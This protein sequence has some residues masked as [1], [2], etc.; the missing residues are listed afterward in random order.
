MA[1]R[2]ISKSPFTRRI[3]GFTQ[4]TLT[5][6]NGKTDPVEHVNHFN[7]RM[8]VHLKNE[9]LMC[10]VFPSSLR[11]MAMRWFD[12]LQEGSINSFK[13]L[14]RAFGARFVTCSRV[15]RPLNSLLSMTMREGE[16]LKT[17][18][19]KYWEM[20]NKIDENFD[21]VAIRTLKVG[22]PIEYDLRK[23]LTRK[24]VRNR[25]VYYVSNLLHEAEVRYL[26]LEKAI[27]PVVHATQKL[28]YYFQAHI[29][30]VLT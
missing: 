29:V 30:V 19:D 18:L 24:P 14:T 5:M 1:L 21:D 16:T 27:L 23:S 6:Y 20:F 10:K 4:P 2:Q 12:G 15:S 26:P 11:P 25:P 3:E 7:Q 9:T 28:P 13:E 8:A 22:L 17:Y